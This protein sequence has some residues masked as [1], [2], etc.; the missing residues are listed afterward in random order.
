MFFIDRGTPLIKR[1][2]SQ[3]CQ[4]HVLRLS[5]F[6]SNLVSNIEYVIWFRNTNAHLHH[7][8]PATLYANFVS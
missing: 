6:D 8:D 1:A 2:G 4:F 7:L 5:K 3:I